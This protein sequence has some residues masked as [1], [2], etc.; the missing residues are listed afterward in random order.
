MW[1]PSAVVVCAFALAS[2]A[3]WAAEQRA[4]QEAAE[5][6]QCRSYGAT[7]G[8]PMYYDCRMRLQQLALQRAEVAQQ[9]FA[10]MTAAGLG[11]AAASQPSPPQPQPPAEDHVCVA[12]NNVLY[13]C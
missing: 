12:A 4:K 2:C 11:I 6:A 10:N 8:T 7:P 1:K 3:Q 13:R 9:A 5:D